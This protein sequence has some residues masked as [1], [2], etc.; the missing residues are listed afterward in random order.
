[1][2]KIDDMDWS[3]RMH[4][5]VVANEKDAALLRN[6][7]LAAVSLEKLDVDYASTEFVDKRVLLIAPANNSDV[8][9]SLAHSLR[10]TARAVTVITLPGQ[11]DGDVDT[12]LCRPGN[13]VEKLV[14]LSREA[15]P[16][17]A[18][19][20]AVLP[21]EATVATIPDRPLRLSGDDIYSLPRF[22]S[23][24]N[25]PAANTIGVVA[26]LCDEMNENW[27]RLV[28][29]LDRNGNPHQEL[30]PMEW[31]GGQDSK[32][33]RMLLS[34]GFPVPRD[35]KERDDL[36]NFLDSSEPVK[37]G[38]RTIVST[39]GWHG[40]VFVLPDRIIGP[41]S[42][43]FWYKGP[44]AASVSQSGT[45]EDWK[46]RLGKYCIGNSRLAFAVSCAFAGPLLKLMGIEN[47]GVHFKGKNGTGKS[48][49]LGVAASVCGGR[50]YRKEWRATI[51]G[52]EMV[53]T[54]HHNLLLILDELGQIPP[55]E[56]GGA[57]YLLGNG[58]PK[59]R[60]TGNGKG[61]SRGAPFSLLFLS[62]G[63][64]S[65]ADHMADAGKK[66]VGGQ[67]DRLVEIPAEPYNGYG[68]YERLHEFA[69]GD[70]LSNHLRS[71]SEEYYG[72]PLIAYL[73]RL[74]HQTEK[75]K[76]FIMAKMEEFIKSFVPE[77]ERPRLSRV[78]QR[79]SLIAAAGELATLFGVTGWPE[80]EAMRCAGV[81]FQA[82]LSSTDK[83]CHP[84]RER[85]SAF[86]EAHGDSRFCPAGGNPEDIDNCAGF[87]LPTKDGGTEFFIYPETFKDE[88]FAGMICKR[89]CDELASL[90]I[91]IRDG[92]GHNARLKRHPGSAKA[93]R[94][95]HVV[96]MGS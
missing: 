66:V 91:L 31:F 7:D 79:F 3:A 88:I 4:V 32:I 24:H 94:Y 54:H 74:T 6:R 27:M 77:K 86:L 61:A 64:I 14:E 73:E 9:G 18:P 52:L 37:P 87:R 58:S 83:T 78:S 41:D 26:V 93:S 65:L 60:M 30:I 36:I 49:T 17:K 63:E 80:G 85:L 96:F 40:S 20:P 53:G 71:Q 69:S 23:S 92:D 46:Q 44:N 48:T 39:P 19:V 70:A 35:K 84:Y 16:S 50:A 22:W 76:E 42:E 89:V 10:D 13:S 51:N 11:D 38:T 25:Q 81:C 5:L 68:V 57:V 15:A 82:W 33:L 55:N 34:K 29:F 12:W 72:E 1:M 21:D 8:M 45:L 47:G 2:G 95:Y 62:N 56:V 28:A 59:T 75:A 67:R 90:G 43:S